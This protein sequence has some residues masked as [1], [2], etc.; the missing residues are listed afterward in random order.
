MRFCSELSSF[1]YSFNQGVHHGVSSTNHVYWCP[2]T[3]L[4]SFHFDILVELIELKFLVI[5]PYGPERQPW[6]FQ[7]Y[8]FSHSGDFE[9]KTLAHWAW[10]PVNVVC[11]AHAVYHELCFLGWAKLAMGGRNPK[12][13]CNFFCN[14]ELL[15]PLD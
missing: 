7:L 2:C 11:W 1:V 6:K 5:L 14:L 12:N 15:P 8:R 10:T 4:W 13:F 3:M 9:V